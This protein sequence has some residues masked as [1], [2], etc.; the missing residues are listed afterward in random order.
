M[1]N[2]ISF[3]GPSHYFILEGGAPSML[4]NYDSEDSLFQ[5]RVEFKENL[6][7]DLVVRLIAADLKIS[8]MLEAKEKYEEEKRKYLS[9]E[10]S[11]A[12]SLVEDAIERNLLE[13]AEVLAE[14]CSRL[15]TKIPAKGHLF[16]KSNEN[17]SM[18]NKANREIYAEARSFLFPKLDDLTS[19]GEVDDSYFHDV[20]NRL[21]SIGDPI[22]K[23]R[24]K[25]LA[26]KY[27][28]KRFDTHL[29]FEQYS[30]IKRNFM[31]ILNA[32]AIVASFRP[33]DVSMRIVS[34]LEI[35]RTAKWL[36]EGLLAT[37]VPTHR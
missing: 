31:D 13:V 14:F 34:P 12:C 1:S 27:D 25:V 17:L 7:N 37:A 24:N 11:L 21:H 20:A 10:V 4:G 9:G 6:I 26:H 29:S 16:K 33:N 32:I 18:M 36:T 23:F 19:N 35:K 15:R 8:L 30:E 28:K 22:R 5:E 3:P 2:K